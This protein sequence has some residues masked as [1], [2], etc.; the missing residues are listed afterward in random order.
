MSDRISEIVVQKFGGSSVASIDHIKDIAA[1]VSHYLKTY[2]R[3]LVIVVSAMGDQTDTLLE[4][5]NKISKSPAKRELDMLL[6]SGERTTMALLAISLQE[7]AISCISLTGSQTGILT[8]SDHGNARI[9]EIKCERLKSHLKTHQVIIVA[10]FQGVDPITKEI[11]TLGRGGSDLTAV[12]LA[13]S[14]NALK[15]ELYKDVPGIFSD[16][17]RENT[18]ASLIE[19]MSWEQ[20]Y[21]LCAAGASII[22]ARAVSMALRY[23]MP[24]EIRSSFGTSIKFTRMG[25]YKLEEP[26]ISAIQRKTNQSLFTV[27]GLS[28]EELDLLTKDLDHQVLSVDFQNQKWDLRAFHDFQKVSQ[29]QNQYELVIEREKQNVITI[30]GHGFDIRSAKLDLIYDQLATKKSALTISNPSSLKIFLDKNETIEI[31][32]G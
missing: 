13:V 17:P 28:R 19:N 31:H 30:I 29:L 9:K 6:S 1:F 24:L 2:S 8:N 27:K 22:H 4:M 10:G 15:C 32:N 5:A 26:K 14:L 12:A 23:S 16:D 3:K 18:Q 25:D 21:E 11:T 7:N 20:G